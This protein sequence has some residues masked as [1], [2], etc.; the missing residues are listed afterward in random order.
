MALYGKNKKGM[1]WS[2]PHSRNKALNEKQQAM[3]KKHIED[4]VVDLR[5]RLHTAS[6]NVHRTIQQVRDIDRVQPVDQRARQN[7]MRMLRMYM[8]QY[9]VVQAMCANMDVVY[10][11][12]KM[13]EITSEFTQ[14]VNEITGLIGQYNR[15]EISPG[16]LFRRLKSAMAPS[17]TIGNLNEYDQ[18]YDEL[19]AMYDDEEMTEPSGMNDSWLEDIVAGR[20]P[21]DSSPMPKQAEAVVPQPVAQVVSP[22][23]QS[24]DT[25]I[26]SLLAT[27]SG[28][29]KEDDK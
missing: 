5:A 28:A 26:R 19:M 7:S 18:L 9:R 10:S 21:W 13:R 27:I 29:L 3:T 23:T 15:Q 16:K 20:I 8:G 12:M 6:A 14:S 11:E 25:D 1:G 22:Q 4:T 2:S 17:Q 24:D